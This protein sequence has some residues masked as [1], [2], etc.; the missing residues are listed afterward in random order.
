MN[1]ATIPEIIEEVEILMNRDFYTY[2][3]NGILKYKTVVSK[4]NT[5][6]ILTINISWTDNDDQRRTAIIVTDDFEYN[7]QATF[8]ILGEI[9]KLIEKTEIIFKIRQ[10]LANI[11]DKSYSEKHSMVA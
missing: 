5:N 9:E 10:V 3:K 6:K 8:Y 11:K 2:Q 4:H 1:T 7:K